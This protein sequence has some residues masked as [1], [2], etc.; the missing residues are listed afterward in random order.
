MIYF[1]ADFYFFLEENILVSNVN[2]NNPRITNTNLSVE[3]YFPF[4]TPDDL[5][6]TKCESVLYRLM[7]FPLL[8]SGKIDH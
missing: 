1:I 8:R 5:L 7:F 6:K 4:S 3:L 2:Y